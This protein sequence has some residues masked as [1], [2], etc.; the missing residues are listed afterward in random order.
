[1]IQYLKRDQLDIEKYDACIKNSLQSRIYAFSWYLDIVAD[2]W[3]A[4]ILD[5]YKAVMPLPLKKKYLIKYI[6]NP[7]WTQQLGVFSPIEI[8]SK[9]IKKFID[10]LSYKAILYYNFNS[11]NS[12]INY[13]RIV[14]KINYELDLS[15]TYNEILVNFRKDRIKDK[16]KA[17]SN[18][19][20]FDDEIN[21]QNVIQNYIEAF[22]NLK[23]KA[24]TYAI[25]INLIEF[26][27]LN[28]FAFQRNIYVDKQIIASAFF[29]HVNN[30]IYYL[31]GSSTH[32][33]KKMGATTFLIDSVLK[34]FSETNNIFDFEG[35]TIE[36]VGEFYKSFGSEKTIYQTIRLRKEIDIIKSLLS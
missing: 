15:V 4:L 27:L 20:F 11:Q 9:L 25:L 36:S 12:H 23:I 5:D 21:I 7:S 10:K 13:R 19:L 22:P 18:K 24:K 32:I 14:N 3:D 1:M 31:L 30:R 8:T 29:L 28:K 6:Y 26:C 17:T 34:Q 2:N 33:G 16:K 35:S